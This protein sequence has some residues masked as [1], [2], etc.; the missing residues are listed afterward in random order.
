M[1]V[2]PLSLP[3]I[4]SSITFDLIFHELKGSPLV[5]LSPSRNITLSVV[6]HSLLA[7]SVAVAHVD[8]GQKVSLS[9]KCLSETSVHISTAGLNSLLYSPSLCSSATG[10]LVDEASLHG[11][12]SNL[13]QGSN[14]LL[15]KLCGNSKSDGATRSVPVSTL[16]PIY[17]AEPLEVN[18]GG[19]MPLQWK[20][21]YI[22]P[23]HSRFNLSNKQ[24]TFSIVEGPHHGMLMLDGQ[25]CSAFDYS[26][27][28][29][30][31]VIYRHDGSETTQDQLEFQLDISSKKTDF[32]WLDSTTYVLRIRINPVNDPPE[33]TEAKGGHVIKIS[34]KGSRILSPDQVLLS[35]PD[36]GPDK[37]RV[38]VVEGR[39]V[40]LRIRNTTITE[41]TQRQFI[42]R[43]VSIHDEGLYEKGVLRLVARDGDARSQVLTLHTVS[44]PVEVRLK[45]NTGVRLLHHSSALITSNNLS[46]TASV[47]DLPLSFSIVGL[48]DHGVVECSPEQGH[49]AVCSTFTQDQVDRGLVRF[50][51][52]SN[53]HPTHD[54]F[55][56]QVE[57]GDFVSMIH[58]FR[59]MFIPMNVKVFNREV[60]MLNGTESG[61]LSR[62]N[63]FAWTFPKSYPPEKLV[64]HIEEPPKYGIL[65]RKI[66]GKSRR[67]GVSSNFTQADLDNQL[68][69]FKLHFMQYSII[70]DFF[71]F[72]VITP[73]ISSESLRF[74]I[75]FVPTQTSI[76]LVNRTIVV[77][78][79]EMATITSDSLSLATPDDSFFVFTL[80]LAPIQ[81]ALILKSDSSRKALTTGMN[82][83][84]KDI[85]EERLIY[86]HSGSET[87]TDR[88][89]LI[90]ESA[91]RKGRRIPF[92]MSFSII[93]VN[94][95][96]PRLHGSSTLQ[97]VE[98]G[99]R[100]L[101]PYLLNWVD[102][103]SDGAPLQFNFYQP[104][105]DAAVLSTVSPYH[106]MTAFTEKDLE[107]G[108]IMLRHLGH[109]SNFTISYTVS[110]GKHTVEGLLRI[111]ASDPFVRL[112]ESLLEYCCLPGDTPNLPV[113]PLNLSI[114]SNLDIRLEDI[115]Y[116]MESDNFA[117]QHHGSRR[118]T[119]TFTQK[120]IN[121]GKISYN[122]GSA[123]TEPFTVRVGN[124][125]LTSEVQIV[126]RSL[127]ASLELRRSATVS[128][129]VGGV[130]SID[131]SH[132]EIGDAA[133]SA[134]DLI[135][136]V[137]KPPQEG[138][139]VLERDNASS[140]P[141]VSA[142][143]FSQRDID[144]GRLQYI[145]SASGA[146][147][148]TIQ[149][150]IT[151]PHITKGPYTL[152]V[153]IYEHHVSLR[154]S[155][156]Q[157]VAGGSTVVSNSV[158][159]VTSSDREDYVINVI[160]KPNYGWIV[161]DSWSVNNISS[162]ETFSG[163]DLRER[164]V[165]YVS[166][167]DSSAT[168]DSFS[169]VA[170]ISHHTCTQPQIV[171]VT[172][173]QRNVQSP[174]LLRN[175]ILR[176]SADKTLITN[177]HL[178]TEDPDTPSSGVFF[179][180]S[181]PSNGLVVNANDL[182]KSIYN[183]SQK[184]VDDSS[185]IFMRH[186]NASGSGGFSFL[187][188]D[189][190]HQIGPEW[191]SIEGWTS[192][193]PVLQANARLLAS[194]SA[195][196]V[197]GVES[198]RA[199][200]PNSRPEEILYSVSR[201]PKY[202]KLLVDSQEAEKFSQLDINRN[203]LVYNNEGAPQKEW[204]RK[205]SFHFVL[206]KNGSDT[207]IEEEFRFR[208]SSTYAALHDPTENYVK[209]SPLNTSKGGSVALTSA[210]LDASVLA[211]SAADEDL[212]LE[213]STPPRHGEL[214]FIDGAASQLTWSDF[215]A[216]TKLVYRHGGE[217]SRDDSV[218]FFI[219]P[220]SEKTRRSSRLRVTL[221]IH[222]TTLRDPL[223]QVSKFPTTLSIRNSGAMPLSP[224]LFFAS[225]PHVPPQSIVY[226]ITHPGSTG[227]EVRV[228]GQR[229]NMFSQ[230]QVNEGLVSIGHAPSSSTLSSHDVVVFS[231][232]GHSRA[233]IVRIK[234]LDLAL[235]NHTTIEYPQGK[236][237]VV[238]NRTHLGAYSNG[239][240]SAITYKI[241]SG[242]ENGT[243]YWVAGEKEAKQFT[244]KDIDDGKI[245]YAQLN[246]HSYK[247]AF[248]FV[249]ANTEKGV[250]RNRSEI[251][252]RPLVTAQP[253]IVETNSAVPLTAS[254]LNASALQGSTP[255]FLIT[256]TPQYGRIS[257]DPTANHSVLFFTFPDILRG[258]V[259]YQ[260][261]TT[262]R[263]VTENLELE[264]RADSVQPARLILPITIIPTDSEMPEHL[265]KE[266]E[267]QADKKEETPKD[268][269]RSSAIS[270]QLPVCHSN[271]ALQLFP[272]VVIILVVI[273]GITVCVLL[274]R[275]RPKK[276]PT[277]AAS[278]PQLAPTPRTS[279]PEKP[280][281]LGSTVFAQVG[282]SDAPPRQP[283]KTFE[284][285]QIT[286]LSK[287]RLQ[288][289]LDYAGLATDTPPP[290][291]LFKQLAAQRSDAHHWV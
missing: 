73:A 3:L 252:V 19:S 49:F 224:Q 131:T 80:A 217:E 264:V 85:A 243:F 16:Q 132:L 4:V 61:T 185:V 47:P 58:N 273:L 127:G 192:S 31:S 254:Q 168:R 257:L 124:Q 59:L 56:F 12:V 223:V 289:S 29:S 160:E 140:T 113:S 116:Q 226:E 91:F 271:Y 86:T 72:R 63:L 262:D 218:T 122:V 276:K 270:D 23:E 251:L 40:H 221:P 2:L 36:D 41:F 222:I 274:C 228:N 134:D 229:R 248:E 205:D 278:T 97:I 44:T 182:S 48:P 138:T 145:H 196:T 28:L 95:N 52:T 1:A 225:H 290:M 186:P 249:M 87:R 181:R 107:Q 209:I 148:D 88:L 265:E 253:V 216:E 93:P 60:F 46:F 247:D 17:V 242:P 142:R 250:V 199:N 178:D 179:L 200:I 150:N 189:G 109:K 35:D 68:I 285:T 65:S 212:I 7:D 183:F 110:D 215:Q 108:R 214:E 194:P 172:L 24:I 280:D 22:L 144:L 151:S 129:P 66:N 126:R 279:L 75:I 133:S 288:P 147:R 76:Q 64:Y 146:G 284:R 25:P 112:G 82:F 260:A 125:S 198:L 57:S 62:A 152:Y 6:G 38:Q 74:E 204:T 170:C 149:F 137:M 89:H 287:R 105:K 83:T 234:P 158:I 39:G 117:I 208:I 191:F 123:A 237:Y 281:L 213:V 174:Q 50:R 71:L 15:T 119:R 84:T 176:V 20:N 236:T 32:P 269:P 244:Q 79:G 141:Q 33:L 167:R 187:L 159:N 177:A 67:I 267:Q 118:P 245:L 239:D 54:M 203:R 98:R 277:P 121:E 13:Y 43:V 21:I 268:P 163:S 171:D 231:V 256:S 266:K 9:V 165:V 154:A 30:R 106:P 263:E 175:E 102:D 169:V 219:Y 11:C 45:T 5:L 100:V 27:L 139:L 233:L 14:L 206:Q 227:T 246:M 130:V 275:R 34:A 184:D 114:V 259:Y 241:V 78:E 153:E 55:S 188:S 94:D 155:P 220:A 101:H 258:R 286:P 104:I 232:E 99:E 128:L 193:S 207:P 8:V 156:L 261:F 202:G 166:D 161:L 240:R 37:V 77:Q 18:E 115:V 42:N 92:W 81:G 120:D 255:R 111:V 291:P 10:V 162:I 201:P 26:Q 51:H 210:H 136:H 90:A 282:K 157:V 283:L 197:I 69:S 235:E 70:N 238:L 211:S 164:R 135:Y 103:D 96:K 53:H 173:S 143:S 190:V 230:E 180:I 272:I 195:S